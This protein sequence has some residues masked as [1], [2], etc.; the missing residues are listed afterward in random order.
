MHELTRPLGP[1]HQQPA[2]EQVLSF[3]GTT[4]FTGRRTL[5]RRRASG[6]LLPLGR[7]RIMSKALPEIEV[8]AMAK[9][10]AD[11]THG[12]SRWSTWGCGVSK[13]DCGFHQPL[14]GS[15]VRR[16]RPSTLSSP[17]VARSSVL[18]LDTDEDATEEVD[19]DLNWLHTRLQVALERED[20]TEALNL[21][22]RI[23]RCADLNNGAG[24]ATE[25]AWTN[26]GVPDWLADRLERLSLPL[27]TRVQLHALRA[28]ERGDDAAICAP[29]GSGKTLSYVLPLLTQLSEDLLSEDLSNYLANFLDGGRQAANVKGTQRRRAAAQNVADGV[30]D[31]AVPTPAVLI[32]VPTREVTD[33]LNLG[34]VGSAADYVHRAGRVGRVEELLALGRELKFSPKARDPPEITSLSDVVK[35]SE[36]DEKP[37]RSGYQNEA[38]V[39]VL[40]DLFNLM[41]SDDL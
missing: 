38:A 7:G 13:F 12:V 5:L 22:D 17:A 4:S 1:L 9:E 18:R 25:A 40:A 14:D 28:A 3:F 24:I 27:P 31:T 23:R 8:T 20:Y 39:Q 2:G 15:V 29:T 11:R 36:D 21:R 35:L 6:F 37:I 10:D 19:A 16:S 33:V 30:T 34:I 41:T 32:V 26:L